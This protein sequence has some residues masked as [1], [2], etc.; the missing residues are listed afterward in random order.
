MHA[1]E[2]ALRFHERQMTKALPF[3]ASALM[4]TTYHSSGD[5]TAKKATRL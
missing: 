5:G 2:K 4:S 1:N 3:P